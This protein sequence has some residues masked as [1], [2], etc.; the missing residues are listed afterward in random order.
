MKK[1]NPSTHDHNDLVRCIL[2][3]ALIPG[4]AISTGQIPSVIRSIV[5]DNTRPAS[6]EEQRG[7]LLDLTVRSIIFEFARKNS[8]DQP[9]QFNIRPL[10]LFGLTICFTDLHDRN[11]PPSLYPPASAIS[12]FIERVL[13]KNRPVEPWE[14]FRFGLEDTNH[15]VEAGLVC[16]WASR[17]MARDLDRRT[18]PQI[19]PD[20]NTMREWN[21]KLMPFPSFG[22][23]NLEPSGDT[24]YFWTNVCMALAIES[25]RKQHRSKATLDTVEAIYQYGAEIMVASRLLL[26]QQK[27][28]STHK[29]SAA[30]G[31]AVGWSLAQEIL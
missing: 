24:Y 29:A 7:D 1:E 23:A 20:L 16:M 22:E 28:A 3:H 12:S 10:C 31:Y 13:A 6:A 26:A 25:S 19:R 4:W 18:Y 30:L 9:L 21:R 8:N 11:F 15:P 17:I 14:Q 27:M 5:K 2:D